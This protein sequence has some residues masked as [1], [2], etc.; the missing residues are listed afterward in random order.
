MTSPQG[1]TR[2]YGKSYLIVLF[3]F[4]LLYGLT[5]A[6]G[7]LWQDSGE[8]HYRAWN[9]QIETDGTLVRAHP[10]Y[11]AICIATKIFPWGNFAGKINFLSAIL[12]AITIAN[13]FILIYYCTS[14]RLSALISALSLGLSWTFWQHAAIAEVYTLY[15][16]ILS[17][18]LI[19]LVL[20]LNTSKF[21]YLFI[22]FFLNGLSISNHLFGIFPFF[23]YCALIIYQFLA[24]KKFRL[25]VFPL[26]IFF[27]IIGLSPYLT[28]IVRRILLTGE[29]ILT[30]KSAIFG[31]WQNQVTNISLNFHQSLENIGYILYTFC[32]P[33]IFLLAIGI[34]F[35][36]KNSLPKLYSYSLF[37]LLVLF[38]VFAFRY[39]V[40]D[41]Y[42]FFIPFYLL[43]SIFIGIG[44]HELLKS[45]FL[46]LVWRRIFLVILIVICPLFF[47][48]QT[49]IQLERIKYPIG[50]R[51]TIP[52]RNDYTYFLR[53]W[54]YD[55]TGPSHFAE[56]SFKSVKPNSAIYADGTVMIPLWIH[57]T[58]DKQRPDIVL[59][60]EYTE[61]KKIKSFA[62]KGFLY[63]VSPVKDYCPQFLLDNY[64]F[65]KVGPLY[66][67]QPK[68]D[69]LKK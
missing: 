26:A 42:A 12:G 19:F 31:N 49:P 48:W 11:I 39:K 55:N 27:W 23:I 17:A 53:P 58:I 14:S 34:Y 30:L 10:L 67:V 45:Q 62:D 2:D 20:Y 22:L 3:C 33:S 66:H 15:T 40:P 24:E 46:T 57:Q 6:P 7:S 68:I 13:I 44:T 54:Q 35:W 4:L 25:A 16:A 63:V 36:K 56:E 8:F 5:C 59:V 18:E 52:Y 65:V 21:K 61:A 29:W 47:Y 69:C 38:F 28:L 32:S 64:D 9:N 37:A 50:T 43:S 1:I 41:R 60:P 51:R